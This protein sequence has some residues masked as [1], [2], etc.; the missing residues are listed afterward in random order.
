MDLLKPAQ[1][2]ASSASAI[3]APSAVG[4]RGGP[5]AHADPPTS[6]RYPALGV[7]RSDVTH[8]A[9]W[10][11]SDVYARNSRFA[12]ANS[13]TMTRS[14]LNSTD[15]A[16]YGSCGS[17]PGR[18]LRRMRERKDGILCGVR[19]DPTIKHPLDQR[20]GW[21]MT[22]QQGNSRSVGRVTF[23]QSFGGS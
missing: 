3:V 14:P 15:P 18:L 1:L 21:E 20:D 16:A 2:F 17:L 11:Y 8:A 12:C 19:Y 6:G 22:V 4:R 10:R 13:P 7:M 9:L 23:P 5:V